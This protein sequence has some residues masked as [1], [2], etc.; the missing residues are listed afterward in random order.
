MF[1]ARYE[2]LFVSPK[3]VFRQTADSIICAVDRVGYYSIDSTNIAQVKSEHKV[4][5][6]ALSA[7]LNTE[8]VNFYYRQISQEGG[9]V[10]AQVKPTRIRSLPI[11]KDFENYTGILNKLENYLNFL[12]KLQKDDLLKSFFMELN[13][14]VAYELFF[15]E[16]VSAVQKNIISGLSDLPDIDMDNSVE[17]NHSIIKNA[18]ER[19]YDPNHPVRN[20]LETLDSIEE[21]RVIKEALKNN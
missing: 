17:E 19:L 9:R 8:I 11:P 5:I 16:S 14:G 18:F 13:N 7:I 6:G 20:N 4:N 10:L 12:S 2:G 3:I 15:P 21:V 1:R